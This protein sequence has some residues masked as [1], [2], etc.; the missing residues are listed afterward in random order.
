MCLSSIQHNSG[1]YRFCHKCLDVRFW[2][3]VWTGGVGQEVS[4]AHGRGIESAEEQL[5]RWWIEQ[6]AQGGMRKRRRRGTCW[7]AFYTHLGEVERKS[8]WLRRRKIY[9]LISCDGWMLC[10]IIFCCFLYLIFDT[11]TAA[12][13]SLWWKPAMVRTVIY[14]I[15]RQQRFIQILAE[16]PAAAKRLSLLWII[17]FALLIF[18]SLWSA[19]PR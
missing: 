6:V 4:A 2:G 8:V 12:K 5:S 13:H 15:S 3:S 10:V 11:L 18:K 9:D 16:F 7:S 1:V 19:V 17:L 14:S